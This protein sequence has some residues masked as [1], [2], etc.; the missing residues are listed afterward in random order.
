M[1]NNI[2]IYIYVCVCVTAIHLKLTQHCKSTIR[3][4]N[5]FKKEEERGQKNERKENSREERLTACPRM[6]MGR[7]FIY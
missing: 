6:E 2:H 1:K 7:A 4:Q 5:K 3:Q